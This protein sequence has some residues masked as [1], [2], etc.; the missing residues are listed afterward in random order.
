MKITACYIT[1]NEEENLPSSL[2]SIRE[3]A[4]EIIVVDTGSVD[5]TVE[6]AQS[7]GA[8]VYHLPWQDD[9]SEPR[10]AALE[11]AG[12]DWIL[13]L[14]ADESFLHVENLRE[15]MERM[16]EEKPLVEAWLFPFFHVDRKNLERVQSRSYH[17]R[18]FRN[19]K[20]IRY[21]GRIHENIRKDGGKLEL[22]YASE[23]LAIRH[24]GYSAVLSK[25]KALRNLRILEQEIEQYG[26]QPGYDYYLADCYYSL[27]RYEEA[28][29]CARRQAAGDVRMI[30]HES[31]AHHLALECMRKL[32]TPLD[33]QLA[34]VEQA[35]E[36][37]PLL[38]DYY[39][40]RGMLLSSMG[41]LEEAEKEFLEALLRYEG[42]EYP[43]CQGSIFTEQV[44]ARA[45]VRLG[46]IASR[47]GKR[48]EAKQ[49]FAIA[50]RYDALDGEVARKR[51]ECLGVERRADGIRISACYMVKNEADNLKRSIESIREEVD[52]IIVVD[53]GSTDGTAEIARSYGAEV[54]FL[55]WTDD[56]SAP[57]N[58]AL[59]HVTGDW[60]I[61]LDADEY[62][63]EETK[64]N[65]RKVVASEKKGNLLLVPAEQYDST[66][67]QRQIVI[68]SPRILRWQEG[69]H[70]VGRIHEEI[71]ACGRVVLP[72]CQLEPADLK[73]IHTGYSSSL[74][75]VKAERN[76]KILLQELENTDDEERRNR[77]YMYLAETYA[78]L[79]KKELAKYYA[80]K[81][82]ALGRQPIVYASRSYR[83]LLHCLAQEKGAGKE[84]LRVSER[85]T[86]DFPEVPDF[87]AEL[88]QCLADDLQYEK[89]VREAETALSSVKD[90]CWIEPMELDEE[91]LR[92]LAHR[93]EVWER[94]QERAGHIKVSACL[95][96][97]D[98]G[99]DFKLWNKNADAYAFEKIVVDTGSTD[100]TA[101]LA[102]A[103]GCKVY[104]MEWHGDF[105][106]ARNEALSHVTGDWAAV[107]D[108]DEEF[109]EPEKVRP[110]LARMEL[111]YGKADAVMVPIIHIDTDDGNREIKRAPYTRLLRMGRGLH[112]HGRVHERLVKQSG[113]VCLFAEEEKLAIRHTGY[114]S[115]RIL[116][117]LQRNLELL[118][119]EIAEHGKKPQH[120]RYLAD[121]YYGMGDYAKALEHVQMALK[122]AVSLGAQS[123]LCRM[124]LSCMKELE[125]PREEQIAAA[126]Q[127]VE[128]YPDLPDFY[129]LLGLLLLEDDREQAVSLLEQAIEIFGKTASG[130]EASQFADFADEVFAALAEACLPHQ[131]ERA[132]ELAKKALDWN[133]RN[134]NALDVICT[135]KEGA[136]DGEL[137]ALLREMLG[138]D[139][140]QAR[141]L[142]RFA[143][144]YGRIG[145]L[146]EAERVLAEEF[147]QAACLTETY[148]RWK[149]NGEAA[150]GECFT[151]AA[152]NIKQLP[153]V[154][155][156]L[157][158]EKT[159][160]AR[161]LLKEAEK[162][163]PLSMQVLWRCY[164][165]G[166]VPDSFNKKDGFDFFMEA[167]LDW[168]T[169]E[170]LERFL[171]LAAALEEQ[172]VWELGTALFIRRRWQGVLT[173]QSMFPADSPLVNEEFWY[174]LGVCFYELGEEETAQECM[175]KVLSM[176]EVH[177]GARSYMAW[178]RGEGV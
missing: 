11:Y 68:Y 41:R 122:G 159:T 121:C 115:G 172:E 47:L 167:F 112:Y 85:A 30:G 153:P 133:P 12:R 148:Q 67:G 25:E 128:N 86:E 46:E 149:E 130:G 55:P 89:A 123:D 77:L 93:K 110:Y 139:E 87:H 44:A 105:A 61:F 171:Q 88:A 9:F 53:T 118:Q 17:P 58:E 40:E 83:I 120:D 155:V 96:V 166:E 14:D 72:V 60:I 94:I 79:D 18:L 91:A 134:E 95:I 16:I 173:L 84:R 101:E 37:Y 4:D 156:C 106:A 141:Y 70:Y 73:L 63:T 104:Q 82:I 137:L 97:K 136:S 59:S 102:A 169:E 165:D 145:L 132:W 109:I 175:E 135:C 28:L 27:E 108:A 164:R 51:K 66:T 143:E 151:F 65:L 62:F 43:P 22:G 10:N 98:G 126:R 38:P 78:G 13:F 146:E 57:R 113:E 8:A 54:Y 163:L 168:G 15:K 100:G 176:S 99:E 33:E 2:E 26:K 64:G 177:A 103:C 119:R 107:L 52:E 92:L 7:Y 90:Y 162:Q 138:R 49:Y 154:M 32:K 125:I 152:E 150:L 76:L 23:A 20:D 29:S 178:M 131:K 74:T 144:S 42:K 160:A 71:R 161:K 127:A 56:F 142:A 45:S 117:K 157:E 140:K 69:L 170:Q 6:I 34:W 36:E 114:S 31:H 21:H 39:A 81:D 48:E 1:K 24:T 158:Q 19:R 80:R 124:L 75:Q 3:V 129:G 174:R 147:R 5:R 50:G 116:G 111:S 35:K